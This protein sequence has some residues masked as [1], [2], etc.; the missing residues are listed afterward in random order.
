MTT[1]F[2]DINILIYAEDRGMGAKHQIAADLVATL[3]RQDTGALS[4]QV[5]AEY[6]NAATKKL[7]MT[8]EEAEATIRDLSCWKIHRPSHADIVNSIGLQRRYRLAWWD[9]MIVNS[10]IESG[11]GILW[12]ADLSNGQ[13]FGALVVRNPL[14]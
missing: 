8:S 9:A 4:T 12:S 7:R 14:L 5:L 11:A 1:E 3:A 13:E 6:C 10:A 2:I